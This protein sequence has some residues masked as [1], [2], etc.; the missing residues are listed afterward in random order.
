MANSPALVTSYVTLVN[1]D[2][3]NDGNTAWDAASDDEKNDALSYARQYIDRYYV[4]SIF[5]EDDAPNEIQMVSCLFAIEYLES[6][7]F[8]AP[9]TNVSEET[10]KAGSVT[11]KTVFTRSEGTSTIDPFPSISSVMYEFAKWKSS[12]VSMV[13][14]V[15]A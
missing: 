12:S 14:L 3:I 6:D 1:A 5:D 4:L 15:R 13:N 7:L 9:E 11:V 2:T 8:T 10:L